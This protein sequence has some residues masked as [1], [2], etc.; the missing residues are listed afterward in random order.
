MARYDPDMETFTGYQPLSAVAPL[1]LTEVARPMGSGLFVPTAWTNYRRSVTI[2]GNAYEEL[3]YQF[4][5]KNRKLTIHR[6]LGRDDGVSRRRRFQ[7]TVEDIKENSN[8][9]KNLKVSGVCIVFMYL[10][11][12]ILRPSIS[13]L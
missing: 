1:A 10:F 7:R 3:S 13:S 12:E 2:N 4:M 8:T 9:V 6:R 5:S 11:E